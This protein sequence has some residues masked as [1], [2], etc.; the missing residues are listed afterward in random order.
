MNQPPQHL[1]G[2]GVNWFWS[3][4]NDNGTGITLNDYS[5][6]SNP[7]S[8]TPNTFVTFNIPDISTPTQLVL[9]L[10]A[11]V[12]PFTQ[13]AID[14][15]EECGIVTYWP[16]DINGDGNLNNDYHTV[17]LELTNEVEWGCTDTFADNYDESLGV[18]IDDGTC[19]YAFGTNTGGYIC[20]DIY[21]L[22]YFCNLYPTSHPCNDTPVGYDSN[23]DQI[24]G[25][26]G[27]GFYTTSYLNY[28]EI[29]DC[30]FAPSADFYILDIE[31]PTIEIDEIDERGKFIIRDN[32]GTIT[33]NLAYYENYVD[34]CVVWNTHFHFIATDTDGRT[35]MDEVFISSGGMPL[36]DIEFD[37]P[38]FVDS[39]KLYGGGGEIDISLEVT[40]NDGGVATSRIQTI[41]VN[42]IDLPPLIDYPDIYLRGDMQY[43]FVGVTLLTQEIT[44]YELKD[45]L[46]NSYYTDDGNDHQ[47]Y[48]VGDKVLFN[49]DMG[50]FVN[51]AIYT[52]D[53]VNGQC[54][55]TGYIDSNGNGEYDEGEEV[56]I[57]TSC[58]TY[59]EDLLGDDRVCGFQWEGALAGE[60]AECIADTNW[61]V[62]SDQILTPGKGIVI[63]VQNSGILRWGIS[64]VEE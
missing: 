28:T 46:N 29:C 25:G 44:Q 49:S 55:G 42:D 36:D 32:S 30:D 14:G 41:V 27:D 23:Y 56:V 22:N 19:L 57:G 13:L 16:G 53:G 62:S 48:T 24:V 58:N 18:T 31:N 60:P 4:E 33:P 37:V 26:D 3:V 50:A 21:A 64:E 52:I 2:T 9:G 63:K 8:G 59:F 12:V 15:Y 51:G 61:V 5:D 40:N 11:Q 47:E 54:D 10:R 39:E 7:V 45:L 1:S 43:N 38:T 34:E 35:L 20:T 17:T 6:G